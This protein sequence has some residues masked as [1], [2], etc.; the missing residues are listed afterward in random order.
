[1]N[2]KIPPKPAQAE[3]NVRY[4]K[5]LRMRFE[6]DA[7][8]PEA[9]L[10][11]GCFWV[12][13]NPALTLAHARILHAAFVNSI[14]ARV[15]PTFAQYDACERLTRATVSLGAFCPEAT[16]IVARKLAPRNGV[17]QRP[18]Y[19]YCAGIQCAF[20]GDDVPEGI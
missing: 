6:A 3:I 14:D 19:V 10:P 16:W 13:W 17:V 7:P 18:D 20:G 8:R 11:P 15:F 1:M 2:E 9:A 4:V 12:P 5:R